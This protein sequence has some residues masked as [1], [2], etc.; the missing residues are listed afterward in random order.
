M[1]S[2]TIVLGGGAVPLSTDSFERY[3]QAMK[4][5]GWDQKKLAKAAKVAEPSVTRFFRNQASPKII[6]K[7]TTALGLEDPR[8][9]LQDKMIQELMDLGVQV[10]SRDPEKLATVLEW[11]K[12]WIAEK[13]AHDRLVQAFTGKAPNRLPE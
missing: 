1:T 13:D 11:M 5:K 2:D 10:R 9:M 4:Q 8:R 6:A 3:R 7:I 12:T